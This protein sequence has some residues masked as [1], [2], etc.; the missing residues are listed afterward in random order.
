VTHGMPAAADERVGFVL[1]LGRALHTHGVSADRLEDVLDQ[2]SRRLGLE[3][4]F[5]SQPTSIFAAFGAQDRQHTFLM[6]VDPGEVHLERLAELDGV[7]RDLLRGTLG[8]ADGSRRVDAITGSRARYGA[9]LTTL[10]FGVSSGAAARFLGGGAREVALAAAIGIMTSVLA[11][12]TGRAPATRRVFEPLAA[13][14]AALLAA[15]ASVKLGALSVTIATLAGIIALIPGLTLTTAMTELSTRHLASGTARLTGAVVLFVAIA[16]GVALGG[17][18]AAIGLGA[19]RIAAPVPLAGWT[20]WLALLVAPLSLM[21]LLRAA[22][23]DAPWILGAGALA[24]LGGRLGAH[25]LGP[26]LGV[27]AGA[28]TAGLAANAY[29]R[30]VDRPAAVALVPAILLLVP[31]SVGFRSLVSLLDR[32]VVLGVETAFRTVLMLSALVAGLLLAN[33]VLPARRAG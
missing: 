13:F 25:A 20:E 30:R 29:A 4:Q 14:A 11:R 9:A 8:P 10:A 1:R 17:R 6:R 24:F 21:V 2:V 15:A 5:F 18:I 23:R 16:F 27:C 28:L 12:L 32:E 7:A 19:S 22:P 3:G 31:G 26:E 33:I